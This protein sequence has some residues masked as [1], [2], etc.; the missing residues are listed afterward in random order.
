MGRLLCQHSLADALARCIL[1]PDGQE[2]IPRGSVSLNERTYVCLDEYEDDTDERCMPHSISKFILAFYT[3]FVTV[4][5]Q[6]LG[7]SV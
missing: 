1:S 6:N 3:P 4:A 5:R 7:R 2:F